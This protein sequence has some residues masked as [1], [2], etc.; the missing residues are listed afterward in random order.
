MPAR[1]DLDKEALAAFCRAHHIRKLSLFDSVLRDDSGPESDMGAASRT[2][3]V[4]GLAAS[5][6]AS[7]RR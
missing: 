1:I 2:A 6:S 4:P 7:V 3:I 5:P